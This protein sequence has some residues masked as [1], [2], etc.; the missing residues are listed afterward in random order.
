MI[1]ET[2]EILDLLGVDSRRLHL[3]WISASE[4]AI[5]AE[6]MRSFVEFV[7]EL[8][9]SPLKKQDAGLNDFAATGSSE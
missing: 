6:E 5:F 2:R 8:G 3:K 7:K 9:E 4:G 1:E